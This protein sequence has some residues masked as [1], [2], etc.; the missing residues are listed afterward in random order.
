MA[1]HRVIMPDGSVEEQP[2]TAEEQ[3]DFDSR[4]VVHA[5]LTLPMIKWAGL[6]TERDSLLASSDW[7]QSP[8]S[9]LADETKSKWATHR[10][11]LR[12]LP[13]ST[14]DPANPSW[15]DAPE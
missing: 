15:P 9:P 7:T 4:E 6:R 14:E 5:T 13:A 8:D 11:S 3:T 2:L 10:Q 1:G 12:D